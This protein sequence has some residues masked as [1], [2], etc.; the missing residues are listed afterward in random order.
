MDTLI[1]KQE[2]RWS[3]RK[4]GKH[5]LNMC[6]RMLYLHVFAFGL[7]AGT[8]TCAKATVCWQASS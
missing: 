6:T 2:F 3:I 1:K 7:L 4:K 8:S 5:V